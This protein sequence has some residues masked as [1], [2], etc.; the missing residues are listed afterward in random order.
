MMKEYVLKTAQSGFAAG[1]PFLVDAGAWNAVGAQ[2]GTEGARTNDR[3]AELARFGSAVAVLDQ[4][5]RTAASSA[6]G[7]NAEVFAAERML[8]QDRKFK[9]TVC[10]LI[11]REG[12]DAPAA[13]RRTGERL[14]EELR[15]ADSEYIRE[16]S[17]D[18]SGITGRLLQLL[19]G[20]DEQT[21]LEPSILVADELTP[22]QLS[23]MEP[24]MILGIVTV[25]GSL[26]SHVSIL[27][28]NLGIPYC[29][30][31]E[32]AVREI[33]ETASDD[34]IGL[35]LDGR[36]QGEG[37]LTIHSDPDVY[38]EAVQ[39]MEQEIRERLRDKEQKRI[40]NK[41]ARKTRTRVYANIAGPAE[42]GALIESGAEGVGLF[43]TELLFL[44]NAAAPSEEEQLDAY[45]QV[46]ESMKGKETVIRT[47]DLGSDKKA[48]WLQLPEEKN[49]A[50]GCRGLRV[51]LQEKELFR[52][53]IR[54]L[55]QAAVS[56]DLKIMVPMIASV[57]EVDA[58]RAEIE[59]CAK[60][61]A[62][63]GLPFKVPPLG[64]MVETPAAA[65]IADELAEKVD[66]F[67]IGTNDL[68]QYTLALDREAQGLDAY[69]DPCHEAVLRLIEMTAAA[70]H[71]QNISTAVCGELAAD[72]RAIPLLIERGVDELSV[73]VSKVEATKAHVIEA[74]DQ[75]S[76]AR[77]E[78]V[79][80]EALAL[81]APADGEL[82]PMEEIPDPAFSSG[83]LGECVGILPEN[84]TVY[85]PCDGIV[86]GIAQ[87]A[88]AI[89]FTAADGRQILVHAGLD[90]VTLGGRGFT[91]LAKAGQSVA[92]GDPVLEMD[93]EVIRD[94]GLSPMV[95]IAVSDPA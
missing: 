12:I 22:A 66:F 56:G 57:W 50:L 79:P 13:I 32:E 73:S 20:G 65:M 33:R 7:E 85:A 18:L 60:E 64:I 88:H 5:L 21:L 1:K 29:Y 63:E 68:T 25:K 53:Q 62:G 87:T 52:T 26:T 15:G 86:S 24:G 71:K 55:L 11:Q 37:T 61:L 36:A 51:S 48:D 6:D 30:G 41:A 59:A 67:S 44:S 91:V 90:T 92:Q 39:T 80:T 82:I 93:L 17:Q 2:T 69:Y 19:G 38:M 47:M 70:G 89:T 46:V 76:Q 95:I 49:P 42:I 54:A 43:R 27:A 78:E 14:A 31:S 40:A 74:E 23:M 10:D 16:R 58:V 84:G 3:E 9:D 8:L 83:T 45:R 77:K 35:I 72:P 94:A 75:L 34:E 28:G 81:A 4:Q